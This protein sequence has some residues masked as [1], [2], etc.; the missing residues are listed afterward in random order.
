MAKSEN[1]TG[2]LFYFSLWITYNKNT[3]TALHI[4][5][6]F[7]YST[8]PQS[9]WDISRKCGTFT[10]SAVDR[11]A[12]DVEAGLEVVCHPANRL[13]SGILCLPL[14]MAAEVS[15]FHDVHAA[16]IV[17]LLIQHPAVWRIKTKKQRCTRWSRNSLDVWSVIIFPSNFIKYVPLN[18]RKPVSLYFKVNTFTSY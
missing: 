14:L 4:F 10:L 3:T 7:Y 9:L 13:D 18:Y 1:N 11:S 8:P 6:L 5:H 17:W 16:T 2:L 12:S 15:S